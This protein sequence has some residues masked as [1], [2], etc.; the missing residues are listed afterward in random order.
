MNCPQCGMECKEL[1]E[2]YCQDCTDENYNN[3]FKHQAELEHWESLTAK[4]KERKI[5]G[6]RD[7]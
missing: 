3:L 2:G 6:T 4:E 5:K 1:V 7:E